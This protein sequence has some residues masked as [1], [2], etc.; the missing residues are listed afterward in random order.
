MKAFRLLLSAAICETTAA[1]VLGRAER[2]IASSHPAVHEASQLSVHDQVQA[3][4]LSLAQQG[5]GHAD[6]AA[7]ERTLLVLARESRDAKINCSDSLAT[8]KE[9][10]ETVFKPSLNRSLFAMQEQ[11]D[12]QQKAVEICPSLLNVSNPSYSQDNMDRALSA[13]LTCFPEVVTATE[14][15][16]TNGC[17][18]TTH[19]KGERSEAQ[20]AC[21]EYEAL[22]TNLQDFSCKRSQ[23]SSANLAQ[24]LLDRK[25]YFAEQKSTAEGF[26]TKC[27]TLTDDITR[28]AAACGVWHERAATKKNECYR[29]QTAFEEEACKRHLVYSKACQLYTQCRSAAKLDYCGNRNT[30]REKELEL[31]EEWMTIERLLCTVDTVI[32]GREPSECNSLP[33]SRAD[34]LHIHYF[35][36]PAAQTCVEFPAPS[37]Q[38]IIQGYAVTR[39]DL[40]NT[41]MTC[42]R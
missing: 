18:D 25:N 4:L 3:S 13:F 28:K 36:M 42:E 6:L 16:V 27:T 19:N 7:V 38:E 5:P 37:D 23:T 21:F 15:M 26:K 17:E 1:V 11:I 30:T 40:L 22:K 14:E 41:P 20:Q 34:W 33:D 31:R 8:I 35:I 12:K 24:Y 9:M 29:N 32:S 10:L 2:S 39:A